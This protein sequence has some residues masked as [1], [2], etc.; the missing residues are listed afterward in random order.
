V[1]GTETEYQQAD[2]LSALFALEL[3]WKY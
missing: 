1:V 3:P 2:R